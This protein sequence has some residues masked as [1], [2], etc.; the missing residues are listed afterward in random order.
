[1]ET[2]EDCLARGSHCFQPVAGVLSGLIIGIW[3]LVFPRGVPWS[4]VNFFSAPVQG[5]VMPENA[6]Y[7][8]A[9]VLHFALCG[10]YGV[11]IAAA[12]R[13]VRAE[14]AI[15]IGAAAGLVLYLV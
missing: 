6:S 2:R 4:S 3:F 7:I 5:R 13:R 1:M 9:T 10:V 8:R 14:W 12:V 15:L 11:A